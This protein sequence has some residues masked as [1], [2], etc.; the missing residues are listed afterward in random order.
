MD[1][2]TKLVGALE[3]EKTATI[4]DYSSYSQQCYEQAI[5]P[6]ITNNATFDGYINGGETSTITD[7]SQ[8]MDEVMNDVSLSPLDDKVRATADEENTI[9]VNDMDC[10]NMEGP[11]LT[12]P[13][14]MDNDSPNSISNPNIQ[15]EASM[16]FKSVETDATIRRTSTPEFVGLHDSMD[17]S[18]Q[19][20]ASKKEATE[21]EV[22]ELEDQLEKELA[23]E[24]E[25]S[26]AM[27]H[28]LKPESQALFFPTPA[29]PFT[30]SGPRPTA[31]TVP[32]IF[33]TTPA[34]AAAAHVSITAPEPVPAPPVPAVMATQTPFYTSDFS[35]TLAS[36]AP[37]IPKQA[38]VAE[39]CDILTLAPAPAL[40]ATEPTTAT[41][42]PAPFTPV[43]AASTTAQASTPEPEPA[44]AHS[45]AGH[46]IPAVD[47]VSSPP[48]E[49]LP[50]PTARP[51]PGADSYDWAP[52]LSTISQNFIVPSKDDKNDVNITDKNGNEEKKE[53]KK[54]QQ[55]RRRKEKG[56]PPPPGFRKLTKTH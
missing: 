12:N 34:P 5:T 51:P 11:F 41:M 23:E 7:S 52:P 37:A 27:V 6:Y 43:P 14:E 33:G 19:D 42:L 54:K 40:A 16:G 31:T 29:T 24:E 35:F 53:E 49:L 47:S 32:S 25:A 22:R 39:I 18:P 56:P 45:T 20:P 17:T 8:R 48:P 36:S 1:I 50:T 2:L 3:L 46:S 55:V 4:N 15:I 13:A 44:P 28:Q 21:E 9:P 38:P 30:Y 26:G 10:D